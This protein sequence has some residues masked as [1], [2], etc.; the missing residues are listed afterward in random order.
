MDAADCQ[1]EEC[2]M[3][4]GWRVLAGIN[5][6]YSAVQCSTVLSVPQGSVVLLT[7]NAEDPECVSGRWAVGG[8]GGE[9]KC[10][11]ES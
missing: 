3:W 6:K 10:G 5:F 7:N 2:G 9:R 8:R 11:L 1:N 4:S